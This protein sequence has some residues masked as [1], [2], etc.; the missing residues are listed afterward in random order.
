[1]ERI[2]ATGNGEIEVKR[3]YVPI[4]VKVPCAHCGAELTKNFGQD[5]LSY[6]S[7][8]TPEEVGIYCETCDEESVFNVTLKLALEVDTDNV[9]KL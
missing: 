4:E 7:L 1:M 3:F 2:E 8:N 9:K 6:P 5:Y